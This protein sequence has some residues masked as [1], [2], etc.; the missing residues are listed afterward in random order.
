M[1]NITK[2]HCNDTASVIAAYSLRVIC[3]LEEHK[4][5]MEKKMKTTL[6]EKLPITWL[7]RTL[8]KT[9][10]PW[11]VFILM[12]CAFLFAIEI[13]YSLRADVNGLLGIAVYDVVI[14][15]YTLA[16]WAMIRSYLAQSLKSLGPLIENFTEPPS[17]FHREWQFTFGIGVPLTLMVV[18]TNPLVNNSLNDITTWLYIL[19]Q[20]IENSILGWIV[21]ALLASAN[22]IT[23]F[24]S[25][26]TIIN[27]FDSSPYRPVASWCLSVAISIMG[28]VTIAVL[29]LQEELLNGVNMVTYI[30]VG[31]LGIFVFFAGMWS[32]HQH[33]LNNKE[34]EINR[35][36]IELLALHREIIT[37]VSGRELDSSRM[38]MEASTG[39]ESHKQMVEKTEDWPYTIGSLGGLATSV[40]VPVAINFLAKIF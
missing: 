32:T 4:S 14:E 1:T 21:F 12:L 13:S 17:A 10:I 3:V 5:K 20:L 38:L 18:L 15:A 2:E 27:V 23:H 29:F 30:I 8:S 33:M 9:R 16:A 36:N 31:L 28:A 35:I 6:L 11:G 7:E 19:S 26:A 25:Q 40:V 37:K 22:Q 39:L 24:I 34:R